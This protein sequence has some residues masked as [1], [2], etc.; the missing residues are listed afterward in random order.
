MKIVRAITIVVMIMLVFGA[1]VPIVSAE[2]DSLKVIILSDNHIYKTGDNVTVEVRVYDNSQLVEADEVLIF[3]QTHWG[4]D[5]I[6]IDV[7]EISPGIYHGSYEVQQDDYYLWFSAHAESGTDTDSAEFEAQIYEERL[8]LDIHFSYQSHAYLWPGESVI[9]TLTT[10]YRDEPVDVDEFTYVEL[11]DPEDTATDLEYEGIQEG[12][13]QVEI[14]IDEVT[15][16]GDYTLSARAQYANA[17]TQTQATITVNVLTVWYHL[18]TV[19]GNT[20]TFNL[21]VADSNGKGV[22]DAKVTITYPQELREFT[23]ENGLAL[24]SV[25]GVHNGITV[26]GQVESGD[27]IQTF[28]G[29]IYTD[30]ESEPQSPHHE[31]FDVLYDGTEFIYSA[32]SKVTRSYRA[33]NDSIPI[34]NQD[35]HYYVTHE[36]T[37]F[38]LT[39]AYMPFDNGWDMGS[40]SKVIK[41]GTVSTT[42]LGEFS[43]SFTA[44]KNQGLVAIHFETGV[45]QE[46]MFS[47]YDYDDD[48]VYEEDSDYIFVNKG[49]LWNAESVTISSE[50]LKV[51][52]STDITLRTSDKPNEKDELFAM[53]AAGKLSGP[54]EIEAPGD[55]WTC[56]VD[57]GDVIFLKETSN[58]N[59][60]K[61]EAVIPEFLPDDGDY[62]IVAG[63][64]DSD[65]G[66]PYVN[67]ATLKEGESAG[68]QNMDLLVLILL[69]GAVLVILII[70]GFGAFTDKNRESS[71]PTQQNFPPPPSESGGWPPPDS[72]SEGHSG[73]P[74]YNHQLAADSQTDLPPAEEDDPIEFDGEVPK[75]ENAREGA[76]K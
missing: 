59:E 42:Q 26:H 15:Q 10:S 70:L 75:S 31:G 74:P 46:F 19:A 21:G 22:S 28:S 73:T 60:Y 52:G 65:S 54:D 2:Q 68:A 17:H 64:M 38:I 32:G 63:T 67:H 50:P 53:W 35:I 25:T 33:Y 47:S 29:Q 18:E 9:A 61:G 40:T 12:V 3:V 20:A 34:S 66:Y 57:G 48:L 27:L 62:T 6:A 43:I 13:Y 76:D 37:D 51:G 8:E 4:R 72:P 1:L 69:G 71:D 58:P 45:N 41:T 30:F 16:N 24:F 7:Q 49:D 39:G 44:P 55:D 5:G 36:D 14:V 56:W 23:D 11:I